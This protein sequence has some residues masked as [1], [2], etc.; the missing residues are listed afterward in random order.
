MVFGSLLLNLLV[1][2]ST[3]LDKDE[4]QFAISEPK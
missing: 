1:R 2:T 3:V 4:I